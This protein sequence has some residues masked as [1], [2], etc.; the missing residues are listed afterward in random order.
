MHSIKHQESPSSSPSKF[1][2]KS[3]QHVVSHLQ[4]LALRNKNQIKHAAMIINDESHS[5]M[6]T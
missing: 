6:A 3:C 5:L 4:S 2:R 1:P